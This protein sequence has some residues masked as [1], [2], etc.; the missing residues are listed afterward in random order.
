VNDL[1]EGRLVNRVGPCILLIHS[2][3]RSAGLPR[4]LTCVHGIRSNGRPL[5]C[6]TIAVEFHDRAVAACWGS[7]TIGRPPIV[8]VEGLVCG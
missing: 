5:C 4:R 1:A 3:Q 6:S 2:R 8:A 7:L